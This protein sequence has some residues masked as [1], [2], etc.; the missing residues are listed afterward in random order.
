MLIEECDCVFMM[1]ASSEDIRCTAELHLSGEKI[2]LRPDSFSAMSFES[3]GG[4]EMRYSKTYRESYLR[5]KG[6]GADITYGGVPL[7]GKKQIVI[8]ASSLMGT[9]EFTL[10]VSGE[11]LTVPVPACDSYDGFTD[12]T[13]PLPENIAD[14]ELSVRMPG[15]CCLLRLALK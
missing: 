2:G 13:V 1:G 9:R 3:A 5:C 10:T 11:K 8:T 14:G 12:C 6:W 4:V 15:D 7:S